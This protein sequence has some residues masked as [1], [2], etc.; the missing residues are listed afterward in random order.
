M[1]NFAHFYDIFYPNLYLY[2]SYSYTYTYTYTYAYTYNS[3]TTRFQE[4][5]QYS[6]LTVQPLIANA[7]DDNKY[8]PNG[9]P[10]P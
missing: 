8:G 5:P 1:F 6:G 10:R 9:Q 4:K 2:L 7:F 3:I